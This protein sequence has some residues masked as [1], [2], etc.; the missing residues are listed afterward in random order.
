MSCFYPADILLP[1]NA[2]KEDMQ[3]WAVIACDQSENAIANIIKMFGK[4]EF[5]KLRSNAILRFEKLPDICTPEKK[6]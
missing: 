1:K 2:S 6:L 5:D 4:R 3:K